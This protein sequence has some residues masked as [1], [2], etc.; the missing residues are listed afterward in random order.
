MARRETPIYHTLRHKGAR[1][2]TNPC[3]EHGTNH[4]LGGDGISFGRTRE[5]RQHAAKIL[6]PW[7]IQ[8]AIDDDM[9]DVLRTQ[10]LWFWREAEEGVDLASANNSIGL[11][12]ALVTTRYPWRDRG[13]QASPFALMKT[14]GLLPTP[15]G[16]GSPLQIGDAAYALLGTT[17]SSRHESRPEQ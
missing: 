3:P 14:C 5:S 8:G 9:T 12:D 7:A 16:D 17:R 2:R 13:P 6:G 10:T 4:T 15:A 1:L 11:T